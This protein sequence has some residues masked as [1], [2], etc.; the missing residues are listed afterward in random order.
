VA[1]EVAVCRTLS[2]TRG[3]RELTGP[4]LGTR[5]A[6]MLVAA[7]AAF[8]GSAVSTDRL[9]EILWPDN[10]P[11]DPQANLATLA[12]RLRRTAGDDLVTAGAASYALGPEVRLDLDVAGQLLESA[13]G[14]LAR[15]EAGLAAASATRALDLLGEDDAVAEECAGAWADDVRRAAAELRREARHLAVAASLATGRA[16]IGRAT[17][18]V[19]ADPFDE[20]AHRDLMRALVADGRAAAALEVHAALTARLAEELGT[21]PDPET[22]R[23]HL[24][25]LRGED[26]ATPPEP[27]PRRVERVLAGREEE[28]RRLDRAWADAATG[29]SSLLLVTG[30]PGIGKTRLL[31]EAARVAEEGAGLVLAARCHPGERSLFLQ[32]FVEALRPVLVGVSEHRLRELVAGHDEAWAWLLP[33][34]GVA[35]GTPS[36]A[37]TVSPD[38]ARRRSYDAVAGVLVALAAEQPVLL[39]LDDLQDGAAATVELTG[40]LARRLVRTRTLLLAAAREDAAAV[41]DRLAPVA[42]RVPL[43]PL[44]PSAVGALAEAAGQARH[45]HDV[46]ARTLGHPLSVVE[47]LR[48]LAAGSGGVPETLASVVADQVAALDPVVRRVVQGASVLGSR[49]EPRTLADLAGIEELVC[50]ESCEQLTRSGLLAPAG[51][52]YEF[53]NDLLRDAVL[54]ALPPAVA[55][56]YHRRAADLLADHPETMAGHALAAGDPDRAA[57]GWL[58]AGRTARLRAAFEDAAELLDRALGC[59][60]DPALRTEVLLNRSRVHEAGAAFAH[61]YADC[62]EALIEARAAGDRRQ[63]MRA[64]RVR[65]GD[66]PIALRLPLAGVLADNEQG[67]ALAAS[68]GDRVAESVFRSRLVVLS[69]S[70]LRLTDAFDRAQRGLAEVRAA[71]SPEALARSLD[72][73]KSVYAYCGDARGLQTTVAELAPLLA[74]LRLLWLQQWS[75]LESS[76]VPAAAGSWAEARTVIDRALELNRETG[77]TAYAG[78]FLAQRSWLARL[79][80]DLSLSLEDGRRAVAATSALEHPWWYATASGAHASALLE[81]GRADEAAQVAA[82]G[83]TALGTEAGDAYRLRCLAPLA[84]ATGEGLEEADR[85]LADIQAPPGQGWVIGADVYES[86]AGGWMDAGRPD[87]ARAAVAPLLAVTGGGTWDSV[88]HRLRQRSSPSS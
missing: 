70:R 44:P 31:T 52:S 6:R 12:S 27:G 68:L 39:S 9:A 22:R 14:R 87:R 42:E 59:A 63:E 54:E 2:V 11:R 40:Y 29:E 33:E 80:G 75:E 50:A 56:A 16:D 35:L 72:G 23:V 4:S 83:L 8:R 65:G 58:V 53:S 5:K 20:R 10:L 73:L 74:D 26:P 38:L 82:E 60:G 36:P 62:E 79:A 61:A 71:G 46:Q 3:G 78:F 64:R 66:A 1:V 55:T 7:L 51:T 32:P 48:A 34:L 77:Y 57:R 30:V 24:A 47:T 76:L 15:D 84:A 49:V 28:V 13:A 37:G 67:L 18:A 25:L 45:S 69:A 43:G 17:A 88:H 21:D 19:R 81:A 85:L 41:I 86:V